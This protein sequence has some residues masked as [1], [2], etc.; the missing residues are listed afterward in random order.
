MRLNSWAVS[1]LLLAAPLFACAAPCVSAP[2]LSVVGTTCS[3]GDK[4]FDIT[5]ASEV[6]ASAFTA[7]FVP[8]LSNPNAPGFSITGNFTASNP[9]G[10]SSNTAVEL[11]Y[12]VTAG[13]GML[14]SGNTTRLISATVSANCG[15]TA[16]ITF[17]NS[18]GAGTSNEI[19]GL[20]GCP[21]VFTNGGT[22]S[23][24]FAGIASDTGFA[25]IVLNTTGT[26]VA[27]T[28]GASFDFNQTPTAIPEPGTLPLLGSGL[29][30]L[31]GALRRS[32]GM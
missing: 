2:L 28:T 8:D 26:G 27:S 5:S 21:S 10:G 1:A 7:T 13:P 32:R 19:F 9:N 20:A 6:G 25:S 18:E 4:T 16:S 22:P 17:T 23:V 30:G 15:D 3:V 12:V 29:L 31:V 14:I 11:D 24:S